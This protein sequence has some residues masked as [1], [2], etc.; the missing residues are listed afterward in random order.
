V[1]NFKNTYW[2]DPSALVTWHNV[3]GFTGLLTDDSNGNKIKNQ[4]LTKNSV[5]PCSAVMTVSD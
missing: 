5:V 1:P 4:T 3:A 2:A